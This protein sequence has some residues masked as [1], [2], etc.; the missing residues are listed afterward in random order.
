[1][2]TGFIKMVTIFGGGAH[3]SKVISI[4][5]VGIINST[6]PV[7]NAI[8]GFAGLYNAG[9]NSNTCRYH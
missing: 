9:Y 5:H 4:T 6:K 2:A 3:V 8:L 1:M 7:R